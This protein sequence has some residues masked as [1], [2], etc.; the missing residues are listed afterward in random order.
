MCV[1]LFGVFKHLLLRKTEVL[2]TCRKENLKKCTS[3]GEQKGTIYIRENVYFG[4]LSSAVFCL[5]NRVSD[6]F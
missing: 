3:F 6:F 1:L 2:Q 5:L 4:F